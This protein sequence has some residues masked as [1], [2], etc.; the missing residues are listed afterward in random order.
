M[1]INQG[2][3]EHAST[4]IIYTVHP[5]DVRRKWGA[6]ELCR[7]KLLLD[8]STF[9]PTA[10]NAAAQLRLSRLPFKMDP[11]RSPQIPHTFRLPQPAKAYIY[12]TYFTEPYEDIQS[13]MCFHISHAFIIAPDQCLTRQWR[14]MGS[15][16]RNQ[17]PRIVTSRPIMV[18][19]S[20]WT[21]SRLRIIGRGQ[22]RHVPGKLLQGSVSKEV[23]FLC[24]KSTIDIWCWNK[25][26]SLP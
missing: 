8:R 9:K 22:S 11:T 19:S 6:V 2:T 10:G 17:G 25:N 23:A 5:C 21:P 12:S 20:D 24:Q 13:L 26:G 4:S 1:Q 16:R 14:Q 7:E 15:R 18:V 3:H